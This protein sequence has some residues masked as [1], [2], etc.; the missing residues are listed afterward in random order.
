MILLNRL[1]KSEFELFL[2]QAWFIWNQRNTVLHGGSFE[3][4]GWLNKRAFDFLKEFQQTQMQLSIPATTPIRNVWQP[5]P[6]SVYKLNFDTTIFTDLNCSGFG[7]IIQND[8]GEVIVAMSVK[9]PPITNSEEVEALAC[10]KALEFSIDADFLE[11]IIK[12]DN[13]NVMRAIS[14]LLP[15]HSLL[16]HIIE[17]VKCLMCGLQY[18]SVNSTRREGNKIAHVLARHVFFFF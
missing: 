2:V 8:R 10:R 1:T 5:L 12:G 7:A 13:A 17:D 9:G 3:D 6:Q 11:L 14:S 4:P 16:G 15:N 18:V